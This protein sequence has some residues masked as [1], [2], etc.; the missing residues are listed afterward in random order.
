VKSTFHAID[1]KSLRR[2]GFH[3]P[4]GRLVTEP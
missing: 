1:Y 2:P 4:L 3:P